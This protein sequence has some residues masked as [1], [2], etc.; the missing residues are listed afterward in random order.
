MSALGPINSREQALK[1]FE[2]LIELPVLVAQR[3]VS[4]GRVTRGDMRTA[5]EPRGL[6]GVFFRSASST[7][8]GDEEGQS[9]QFR[10]LSGSSVVVPSKI[11][12]DEDTEPGSTGMPTGQHFQ[13]GG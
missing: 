6:V 12:R 13:A 10:R 1:T 11:P 4:G 2:L 5:C 9:L 3:M 8:E 7:C